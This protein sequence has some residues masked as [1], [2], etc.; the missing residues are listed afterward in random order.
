MYSGQLAAQLHQSNRAA[1]ATHTS[2]SD[3]AIVKHFVLRN[4]NFYVFFLQILVMV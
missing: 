1:A 2:V 4:I 3:A